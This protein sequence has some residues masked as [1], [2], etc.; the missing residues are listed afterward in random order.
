MG[1]VLIQNSKGGGLASGFSSSNQIVGV[2][3]TTDFLE[4]GTWV[5]A[6][7][8]LVLCLIS[9][10]FTGTTVVDEQRS[11]LEEVIGNAVVPSSGFDD[12]E[13]PLPE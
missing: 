5:L 9:T 10:A 4:K 12:S 6:I 1:I 8:L 7:S 13:A 3:R 11:D 2:K